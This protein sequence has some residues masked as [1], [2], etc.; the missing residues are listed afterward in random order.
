MSEIITPG[1]PTGI[2][3]GYAFQS[4]TGGFPSI[5]LSANVAAADVLELT[6][7]L[8]VQ[9]ITVLIPKPLFPTQTSGT[10]SY[11][12]PTAS[13]WMRIVKNST[14]GGFNV[15]LKCVGGP[16]SLVVPQGQTLWAYSPDGLSVF[17][18][19]A[20]G[21]AGAGIGLTF[22]FQ[23]TP[24]PTPNSGN[25]YHDED[26]LFVAVNGVAAVTGGPL[27]IA[28]DDSL[29]PAVW[30][31]VHDMLTRIGLLAAN[32]G[33]FTT[34]TIANGGNLL[35]L[36][37]ITEELILSGVPSPGKPSLSYTGTSRILFMSEAG[38]LFGG[39][40]APL[41]SVGSVASPTQ[42]IVVTDSV[43]GFFGAPGRE[44]FNVLGTSTMFVSASQVV[45]PPPTDI[46]AGTGS[47]T[48]ERNDLSTTPIANANFTGT[49]I[50]TTNNICGPVTGSVT[51]TVAGA[52]TYIVDAVYAGG[53]RNADDIIPVKVAPAS[54]TTV[55]LPDATLPYNLGRKLRIADANGG[56]GVTP[57]H[58][59]C[60]ATNT[61][62]GVAGGPKLLTS[63]WGQWDVISDGTQ[64]IVSQLTGF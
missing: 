26:S 8:T 15:F 10:T 43:A 52:V 42:L 7:T 4:L 34:L 56:S 28:I 53:G 21:A 48:W 13:G 1:A 12:T 3:S 64:W 2:P 31:G 51:P 5:Q 50:V 17:A 11:S 61:V 45:A 22:V 20:N 55:Q 38:S 14:S 23:P 37:A 40:T 46:F 44:V 57:I 54:I 36:A 63:A 47:V 33:G 59:T 30:T 39:G 25:I 24:T 41:V 19:S 6:G 49:L 27:T 32:P 35:N 9:D 18:V 60:P 62:N 16:N 29:A 58:L